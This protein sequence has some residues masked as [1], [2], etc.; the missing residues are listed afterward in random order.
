M[1]NNGFKAGDEK[2]SMA[3]NVLTVLFSFFSTRRLIALWKLINSKSKSRTIC[4]FG[5]WIA[6]VANA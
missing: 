2:M 6:V 3:P 1:L 5:I 4:W